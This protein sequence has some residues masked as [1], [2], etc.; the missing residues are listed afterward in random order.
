MAYANGLVDM[1]ASSD[2]KT[3][4]I[5]YIWCFLFLGSVERAMQKQ[6]KT[7]A[8]SECEVVHPTRHALKN[9]AWLYCQN[10]IEL[11]LQA[12]ATAMTRAVSLRDDAK[13]MSLYAFAF[14]VIAPLFSWTEWAP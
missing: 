4:T 8:V 7:K 5:D 3:S 2:A 9:P 10:A 13:A 6:C 12:P 11:K 1:L 14:E